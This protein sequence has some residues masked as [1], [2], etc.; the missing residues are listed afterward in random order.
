MPAEI[1][2]AV[3]IALF[4]S[5]YSAT[6]RPIAFR[7]SAICGQVVAGFPFSPERLFTA[8]HQLLLASHAARRVAC[9]GVRAHPVPMALV[10]ECSMLVGAASG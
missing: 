5:R 8:T 4:C 2:V 6:G 7:P 10:G 1:V 9:H 3:R